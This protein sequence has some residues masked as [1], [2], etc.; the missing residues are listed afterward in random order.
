M[1]K[2]IVLQI[3]IIRL[4]IVAY[5]V[6]VLIHLI[7][8][9]KIK[10]VSRLMDKESGE[11]LN[12]FVVYTDNKELPSLKMYKDGLKDI[13]TNAFK[14]YDSYLEAC[15]FDC[16]SYLKEGRI[17]VDLLNN[18][19]DKD[20]IISLLLCGANI[21][22]SATKVDSDNP[23][24]S[25]GYYYR[26]DIEDIKSNVDEYSKASIFE[27][28]KTTFVDKSEAYLRFVSKLLGVESIFYS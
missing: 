9:T 17:Y 15:I 6:D 24:N 16:I 18:C 14:V 26:Y 8:Q 11:R 12:Q 1:I 19:V 20:A 2:I 4:V 22:I 13:K 3:I 23:D 21:E 10:S 27:M 28:Y 5:C 7:M 25:L